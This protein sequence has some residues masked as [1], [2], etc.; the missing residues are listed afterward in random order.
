MITINLHF[1]DFCNFSCKHC[2][3]S[4]QNKELSFEKITHIID[5]ICDYYSKQNIPIR[6]NLAGGEPLLS[7]NIQKVIDYIYNKGV[8]VSLITNGSLLT[9]SF[10]ECNKDKLSMIGISVDS[11]NDYTNKTIGRCFANHTLS[12]KALIEKCNLIKDNKIKLKIN[13]C[14][15]QHNLKENFTNFLKCSK[16][17]RIK[18]LRVLTTH[19]CNL[20]KIA[21]S[22]DEWEHLILKY[23]NID[24][25]VFEDNDFMETSYLIVD[26]EGNLS[27]NN[28]HLKNNSLLNLTME[29]CLISI[30]KEVL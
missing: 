18:F 23:S 11:L 30:K 25:A 8:C 26:S 19:N 14:I 21:L 12:S 20:N 24:H 27:N 13:I 29:E 1:T 10:I 17:D 9:K 4:K 3:I 22:N 16:P 6:I 7:P 28:R 2:F 5:K 15:S